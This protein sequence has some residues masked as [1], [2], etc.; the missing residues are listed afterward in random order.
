MSPRHSPRAARLRQGPAPNLSPSST[1][2]RFGEERKA[3]LAD[4][5]ARFGLQPL[6]ERSSRGRRQALE[7]FANAARAPQR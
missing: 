3:A 6:V 5:R 7:Q 2:R 1:T 4:L